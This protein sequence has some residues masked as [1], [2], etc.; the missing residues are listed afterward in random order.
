M[1][2]KVIK[3]I[4]KIIEEIKSDYEVE[5]IKDYV[6]PPLINME[7]GKTTGCGIQMQ[8]NTKYD[9]DDAIIEDWKKRLNADSW[10]IRVRR[11]QLWLTFYVHY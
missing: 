5:V 10:L 2:D 11:N 1:K 7:T 6:L 8:L 3:Q 9:Y 4:N